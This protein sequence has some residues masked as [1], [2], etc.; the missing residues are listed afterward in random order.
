[1]IRSDFLNRVEKH[2][3]VEMSRVIFLK[4]KYPAKITQA[5]EL[6]PGAR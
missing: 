6:H 4:N 3:I 2:R 1:M 5:P